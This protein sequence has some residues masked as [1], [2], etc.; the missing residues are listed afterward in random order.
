MKPPLPDGFTVGH[1]SPGI[2][3]QGPTP[4]TKGIAAPGTRSAERQEGSD[5]FVY[6]GWFGFGRAWLHMRILPRSLLV[7]PDS[8][9]ATLG[10]RASC[11]VDSA[12][13]PERLNIS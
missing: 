6:E 13:G 9:A 7:G 4:W 2:E 8:R 5:R 3:D 12:A 10:R 1:G 11:D